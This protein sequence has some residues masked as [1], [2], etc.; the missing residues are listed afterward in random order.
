MWEHRDLRPCKCGNMKICEQWCFFRGVSQGRIRSDKRNHYHTEIRVVRQSRYL[1]RPQHTDTGPTTPTPDPITLCPWQDSHQR[2]SSKSPAWPGRQTQGAI[3][4][5]CGSPG[6]GRLA[7]LVV[8]ASASRAA[9]SHSIP[10][11][12]VDLFPG[13]VIP[14]T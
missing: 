10:A 3:L 4:H 13:R 8:K 14:V 1:T 7:G 6:G 12:G 9:D 5:V 11:V 2:N